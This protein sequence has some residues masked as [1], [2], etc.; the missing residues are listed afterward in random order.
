MCR[1]EVRSPAS[2]LPLEDVTRTERS[3]PASAVTRTPASNRTWAAPLAGFTVRRTDA[4]A[5]AGAAPLEPPRGPGAAPLADLP[6]R[7]TDAAAA[8]WTDPLD[9][10]GVPG[11]SPAPPGQ[12]TTVTVTAAT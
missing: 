5:G 4:A 3:S 8:A 11:A 6:V 9:A 12:A 2:C 7:R 10:P 1:S